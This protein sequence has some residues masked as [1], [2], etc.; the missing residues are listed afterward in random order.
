MPWQQSSTQPLRGAMYQ[1]AS[2]P[3]GPGMRTSSAGS[4]TS[5]G[6]RALG[7]R[8]GVSSVRVRAKLNAHSA[9]SARTNRP[10]ITRA[11]TSTT[12]ISLPHCPLPARPLRPRRTRGL[13][14]YVG[15]D[16]REIRDA[17]HTLERPEDHHRLALD[18]GTRDGAE[19]A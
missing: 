4:P 14:A 18:V 12:G 5:R 2:A 7:R 17:A 15:E 10:R 9:T 19:R 6:W 16:V 8:T 11:T 1:A 13:L 3:R